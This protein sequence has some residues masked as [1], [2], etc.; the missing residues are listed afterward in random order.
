MAKSPEKKI[1]IPPNVMKVLDGCSAQIGKK[2]ED[3]FSQDVFSEIMDLGIES[4]IEQ[5][6]YIAL[7]TV[8]DL[9]NIDHD[10]PEKIDGEYVSLG[11]GI[12]PQHEIGKYYVDFMIH[13]GRKLY[14]RK[15]KKFESK[16]LIV[17][18]DSQEFHDRTEKERRYEKERDRYL[19][20]KGWKLFHYTGKQILE[21]PLKIAKEIVV[22]VTGLDAEWVSTDAKY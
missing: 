20:S 3:S 12:F 17:E 15:D 6:L 11:L 16:S 10:D 14:N 13:F 9:N 19:A 8:R 21:D 5:L 2:Q 4:P 18:C 7:C 22:E 1:E